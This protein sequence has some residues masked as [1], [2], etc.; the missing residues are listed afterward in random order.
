M[1]MINVVTVQGLFYPQMTQIN[2]DFL[3]EINKIDL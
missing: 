3:I 1:L 2:T